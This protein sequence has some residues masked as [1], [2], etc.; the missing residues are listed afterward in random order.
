MEAEL[1]AFVL[2]TQAGGRKEHW[3]RC[4][5]QPAP[6]SQRTRSLKERGT[7]LRLSNTLLTSP[8]KKLLADRV[9]LK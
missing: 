9:L 6:G 2:R 4:S 8:E 7:C 1:R 5:P 3:G